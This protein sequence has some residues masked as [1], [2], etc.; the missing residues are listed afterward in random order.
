MLLIL[1]IPT[2]VIAQK[3]NN[4]CDFNFEIAAVS[5]NKIGVSDLIAKINWD[6]NEALKSSK[7]IVVEVVPIIDC[8]KSED[9]TDFKKNILYTINSQNAKSTVEVS[10]LNLMTKCFK[11]RVILKTASCEKTTDWTYY[12]FVQ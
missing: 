9:A 10:H 8:Y 4:N 1:S 12:N 5:A 7:S 3:S 11:F 2:F 6:F